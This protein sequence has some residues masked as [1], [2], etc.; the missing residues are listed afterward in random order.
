MFSCIVLY[1]IVSTDIH[2]TVLDMSGRMSP[3]SLLEESI[4]SFLCSRVETWIVS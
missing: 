1:F 4:L 2:V 3:T